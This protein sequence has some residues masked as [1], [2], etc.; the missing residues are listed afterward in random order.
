MGGDG[1]DG[2]H[3]A[4]M[5]AARRNRMRRSMWVFTFCLAIIVAGSAAIAHANVVVYDDAIAAN[6]QDW[7]W[8]GVTRDFSHAAPVHGGTASIAVTYTAGWSGLQLGYW[9]A[10]DVSAYDAL[11]V[12]VH[13]GTSG[14]QTV[15]VATGDTN[16]G[17]SV[18]LDITPTAG[19]WSQ[20]DVP[21]SDL[22]SPRTVTYISAFNN[23]PG[24]QPAFYLD[25]IAFVASGLPT[26]TPAPPGTGPALTIDAAAN[27]HAIS[28][29]IYGM[30][31]ADENLATELELPVRR[32]GGNATT[33]YNWQNDTNNHASD[34]YFE[35]IPNDNSNPAALPDGSASDQFIDQDRRTGTATLL[36]IPLIGW[37]PKLR[38]QTC[39]FGVS[40]Y[41]A[42][43][44]TDPY[45]ADCGNGVH[46][47]G[48]D[49]TGNDPLDTSTAITPAFVQAWMTHLIARYGTAAAGGVDFY[50]LDN[51]PEL[52]DDT[53]RDVHPTPTSYDEMRSRT[54]AYAAAIKAADAGAQTL[55]PAS[56]GWT[57]YF[58]SALDWAPGGSWWNN[59]Q[60]RLAHG[61]VPFV[62]WYLQQM[63]AYEQQYGRRILDY[64]EIHDY[65]QASGVSLSP[66]G[67]ASTQALRLRSTRSLWDPSYTDE[68]WIATPVQLI[69][70][71]H[72]WVSSDYPGT[73]LAISEYN[74]GGVEHINGALA[75]ADVLGIFGREALDLA[76]MW[77]P[78]SSAQ[79]AAYAFRMYLNYDGAHAHFGDVSVAA[80]S[81]NQDQLA[82]YAAQRTTDGKLTLMIVNK[83]AQALSSNVGLSGFT[84]AADAQVYAYS[85]AN[86]ASIVHLADQ[87]VAP[88]GFTATFPASSITLLIL[89]PSGMPAPTSTPSAIANSTWTPSVTATMTPTFPGVPSP[90]PTATQVPTA[91]PSPG[92]P[93]VCGNGILEVGEQCDDGNVISGDGC[94]AACSYELIPGN[95]NG[96]TLADRHACLLELSVVNPHNVP[97]TDRRGRPYYIQTCKNND[98]SCDFDLDGADH[99]CE[100]HVVA[101]LNN[102]DPH[103]PGCVPQGVARTIQVQRPPSLRD[104]IS[105]S[106]LTAALQN[107]R[108]PVTG[109][110]G[111]TPPVAP[112]D[113]NLCSAPFSIRVPLR[114][115]TRLTKGRVY[116]RMRSQSLITV[117]R[118]TT[119]RDNLTLVCAP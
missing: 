77:S 75:Q 74:W 84:A 69:P 29:F 102:V 64:V 35:N 112:S 61:N 57:G 80:T 44:S 106:T 113:T 25:D 86:L 97:A 87:V 33:R 89:S 31:F 32:W 38:A 48:S 114:G 71:M 103:L 40:K 11:R 2:M 49:V 62:E 99:T 90:T 78:P 101:C 27:R 107:L 7:S 81:A 47:N 94:S 108:D 28:P 50:D 17:T 117:P 104:P 63:H 41:G 37:T 18:T 39:G 92:A 111:L 23:T 60:D 30:N 5:H 93:A 55:G 46:T 24:A 51:E 115:S 20:I 98:P 91:T 53:H 83:S 96:S 70:L 82:V 54:Y 67:G 16:A 119:D 76:T 52:W 34:W 72:D 3:T 4:R 10:L 59:P 56:W 95:A 88:T 68:S 73:K 110:I 105:Y 45:F 43:Q 42:Q 1:G 15:Q 6:W 109:A 36:T 8:G 22:G 65:P 100:F 79:P 9:Q 12:Y 116:L 14:G 118:I 26:P 85:A 58:W 13:G 66:A 21:L 19:T